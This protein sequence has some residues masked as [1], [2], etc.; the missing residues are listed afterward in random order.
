[1]NAFAPNLLAYSSISLW[2]TVAVVLIVLFA[3][4]LTGILLLSGLVLWLI[5]L[6][7]GR[8]FSLAELMLWV[9]CCGGVAAA[10][11][12]AYWNFWMG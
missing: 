4:L 6:F 12:Y 2:L 10:A 8:Q 11:S 1:M 9:A 7:S 3:G 5:S